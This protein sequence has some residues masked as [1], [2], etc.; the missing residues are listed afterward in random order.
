MAQAMFK[1]YKYFVN[2][3]WKRY[4]KTKK[5]DMQWRLLRKIGVLFYLHLGGRTYHLAQSSFMHPRN[6]K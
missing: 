3:A 6:T 4:A 1:T 5:F 2:H